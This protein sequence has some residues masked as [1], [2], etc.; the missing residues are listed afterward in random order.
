MDCMIK[1][2]LI[3]HLNFIKFAFVE[4]FPEIFKGDKKIQ[5]VFYL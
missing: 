2:P 1:N 5:I 3:S 4:I